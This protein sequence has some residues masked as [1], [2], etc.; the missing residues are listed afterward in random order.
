MN[1]QAVN[2]QIGFIRVANLG[3]GEKVEPR[4]LREDI[5]E[6]LVGVS[7]QLSLDR[8]AT[9]LKTVESKRSLYWCGTTAITPDTARLC[10]GAAPVI[11]YAAQ[12]ALK[13]PKRK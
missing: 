1:H 13:N 12:L 3:A 6:T 4:A 5:Q 11:T 9:P 2:H 8:L 7:V 10:F